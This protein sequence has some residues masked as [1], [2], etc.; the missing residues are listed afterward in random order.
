MR[1]VLLQLRE[2]P[3]GDDIS[4]TVDYAAAMA[5]VAEFGTGKQFRTVEALA[6]AMADA[7]L[8]RFTLVEELTLR[9]SKLLPPAPFVVE[10]A[11]VELTRTR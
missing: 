11:G 2:E 9:V 7:I 4:K 1:H 8:K 10:R 5:L 6:S 3:K